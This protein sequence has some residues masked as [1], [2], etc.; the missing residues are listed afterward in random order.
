MGVR[1]FDFEGRQFIGKCSAGRA[2]GVQVAFYIGFNPNC[3]TACRYKAVLD[4]CRTAM[5]RQNAT[6]NLRHDSS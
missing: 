5:F 3:R 6:L 1:K 4:N 2:Q